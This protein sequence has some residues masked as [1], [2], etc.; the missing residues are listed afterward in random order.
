MNIKRIPFISHGILLLLVATSPVIIGLTR[1]FARIANEGEAAVGTS[2][3][4]IAFHPVL[5]TCSTLGAVF[6]VVGLATRAV[7]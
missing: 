2:W 3:V 5:I 1:G 6:I 4:E 7:R